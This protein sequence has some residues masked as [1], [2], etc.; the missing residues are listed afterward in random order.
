MSGELNFTNM[1]DRFNEFDRCYPLKLNLV[2]FQ[3][4]LIWFN[5]SGPTHIVRFVNPL[6]NALHPLL[7]PF[8]KGNVIRSADLFS[9]LAH[10]DKERRRLHL[11]VVTHLPVGSSVGESPQYD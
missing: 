9:H 5:S 1:V 8:D 7:R 11:E 4:T 3:V 6:V 10:H 2:Y